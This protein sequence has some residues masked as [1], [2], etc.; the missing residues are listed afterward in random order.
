MVNGD[1]RTAMKIQKQSLMHT[2]RFFIVGSCMFALAKMYCLQTFAV[3]DFTLA[4][5]N[6]SVG[7]NITNSNAG[8]SSWNVDGVNN[9]NRQ[10]FYYRIGGGPESPVQ[11]ISSSPTV[12]FAQV[13][14]IISKLNVTYAN[15]SYSVQLGFELTGGNPGSGTS[16]FTESISI[17]NLSGSSLAFHFFQYSDF[18]LWGLSGNQT[19]QFLQNP[20]NSQYYKVVQTDGFRTLTEIINTANPPIGAVEANLANVTLSSLTDG[21]QTDL[22]GNTSAGPGNVTFAYQWDVNLAAGGSFQLSKLLTIVPEPSATTL[23]G[24]TLTSLLFIRGKHKS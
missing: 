24:V 4:F 7:I 20:A 19:V 17:Q 11:S 3:D 22:N 18:D 6:S 8:I 2:S 13:P 9:L 5:K 16:G 14:N 12:T 21:S 1:D 23:V 10:W 15:A